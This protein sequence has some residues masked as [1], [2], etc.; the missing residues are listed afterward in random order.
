MHGFGDDAIRHHSFNKQLLQ[1]SHKDLV[2]LAKRFSDL[3]ASKHYAPS[4]PLSFSITTRL[5]K[6]NK[7]GE[8]A[9]K[10]YLFFEQPQG[11]LLDK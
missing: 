4:R 1:G 8:A 10:A 2:R 3:Q 6:L 11:Q 7:S 5:C 9:G